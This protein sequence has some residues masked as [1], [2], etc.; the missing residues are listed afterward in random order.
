[1]LVLALVFTP[2]LPLASVRLDG[3]YNVEL[4]QCRGPARAVQNAVLD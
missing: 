1:M 2:T 3:G 4:G